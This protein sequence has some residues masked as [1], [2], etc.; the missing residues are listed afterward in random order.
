[1]A[2]SLTQGG[3]VRENGWARL[4]TRILSPE[5]ESDLDRVLASRVGYLPPRSARR[6]TR[7]KME[8]WEL[9]KVPDW[10]HGMLSQVS[11]FG[12][13]HVAFVE[14]AEVLPSPV[15]WHAKPQNVQY[16]DGWMSRRLS[17]LFDLTRDGKFRRRM[18]RYDEGFSPIPVFWGG[19]YYLVA[20][21]FRRDP[22]LEQEMVDGGYHLQTGITQLVEGD[23]TG[24][25]SVAELERIYSSFIATGG[26]RKKKL[27]SVDGVQ[28]KA[29]DITVTGAQVAREIYE[30]YDRARAAGRDGSALNDLDAPVLRW[31]QGVDACLK[32][33]CI[34]D[35]DDFCEV[36]SIP[37]EWFGDSGE[38][39]LLEL[40]QLPLLADRIVIPRPGEEVDYSEGIS[41][42]AA[43][44]AREASAWACCMGCPSDTLSFR[45]WEEPEAPFQPHQHI[46]PKQRK[47]ARQRDKACR[48]CRSEGADEVPPVPSSSAPG[49]VDRPSAEN[50]P[51]TTDHLRI[52]LLGDG[53]GTTGI[54]LGVQPDT[55]HLRS[56]KSVTVWPG[57][58][59]RIEISNPIQI[60]LGFSAHVTKSRMVQTHH[61][62]LRVRH[63]PTGGE[64]VG[65]F[66]RP[67]FFVSNPGNAEV[68]VE[69]GDILADFYLTW[70]GQGGPKGEV[71]VRPREVTIEYCEPAGGEGVGL[72][73][74]TPT[75]SYPRT[76]KEETKFLRSMVVHCRNADFDVYIGRRCLG[77]PEGVEV[78]WGNPFVV[79]TDGEREATVRKYEAWL[80][81][82]PE[83]CER[84]RRELKGKV[85]G[86]WCA[87]HLC[88]GHVLARVANS[89][90]PG[91]PPPM[92]DMGSRFTMTSTRAAMSAIGVPGIDSEASM[93]AMA[94]DLRP[95]IQYDH[96]TPEQQEQLA[97]DIAARAIAWE[98][99]LSSLPAWVRRHEQLERR[100]FEIVGVPFPEDRDLPPE[101]REEQPIPDPGVEP[102]FV[103]GE[104]EEERNA[105][106]VSG[107]P[108]PD[109][110]DGEFS[111]SPGE[112]LRRRL[113]GS[114]A[115]P[116]STRD[117]DTHL[118]AVVDFE[119]ARLVDCC[120]KL[121]ADDDPRRQYAESV[122]RRRPEVAA[123]LADDVFNNFRRGEPNT[124]LESSSLHLFEICQGME[125]EEKL[126]AAFAKVVMLS[127]DGHLDAVTEEYTAVTGESPWG[128]T[129]LQPDV[130]WEALQA[131]FPDPH[132]AAYLQ[133]Q[134]A[135][136]RRRQECTGD[137]ASLP[138]FLP[139]HAG[140]DLQKAIFVNWLQQLREYR[141]FEDAIALLRR[142]VDPD[143][144]FSRILLIDQGMLRML[145]MREV[146]HLMPDLI[147]VEK[148][149]STLFVSQTARETLRDCCRNPNGSHNPPRIVSNEEAKGMLTIVHSQ[150]MS[151]V[152]E[153]LRAFVCPAGWPVDLAEKLLYEV[154]Q[155]RKAVS[156]AKQGKQ[157][158]HHRDHD[159]RGPKEVAKAA[160]S[161]A[162]RRERQAERL[163]LIATLWQ[164]LGFPEIPSNAQRRLEELT[165][166]AFDRTRPESPEG[167]SE[168]GGQAPD[169]DPPGADANDEVE[170]P[171]DKRAKRK[172][173]ERIRRYQQS[174]MLPPC[175][176]ICN[177]H[178]QMGGIHLND[179]GSCECPI[180]QQA[181]LKA[182]A[183]SRKGRT[184]YVTNV[185]IGDLA[186]DLLV[187]LNDYTI[188]Q[189]VLVATSMQGGVK[190]E[191][192][193]IVA[194]PLESKEQGDIEKGLR[195]A[196][197]AAEH[198]WGMAPIKRVHSDREKGVL[199]TEEALHE[200]AI[201]LS[202][203]EGKA[204][205][206]NPNGELG[207][208]L[209]SR[210]ARIECAKFSWLP[211]DVKAFLFPWMCVRSA[212][213]MS[214]YNATAVPDRKTRLK[215]VDVPP[216]LSQVI[217]RDGLKKI[218]N[219]VPHGKL[220]WYLAPSMEVVGG[221]VVIEAEAPFR[222]F[223]TTTVESV[224][225]GGEWT[226]LKE[227]D[228]IGV[229]ATMVGRPSKDV[230]EEKRKAKEDAARARA[231]RKEIVE[232]AKEAARDARVERK[233]EKLRLAEKE[234][235]AKAERRRQARDEKA[236]LAD[237]ARE[238]KRKLK[239]ELRTL[240]AD[241][242]RKE[243]AKRARMAVPADGISWD[244]SPTDHGRSKGMTDQE[245]ARCLGESLKEA[246]IHLS[247]DSL[248]KAYEEM[249]RF[250][251]AP[252]DSDQ[253]QASKTAFHSVLGE[254]IESERNV[255]MADKGDFERRDEPW[256]FESLPGIEGLKWS[257]ESKDGRELTF[258]EEFRNAPDEEFEEYA[259][260]WATGDKRQRPLIEKGERRSP[261]A[262]V[263][264]PISMREAKERGEK[265]H[266]AVRTEVGRFM[267]FSAFGGPVARQGIPANARIYRGKL[268]YSIKYAELSEDQ[269]KDKARIVV[270]GCLRINRDGKI[271]LEKHFK[272]A[273]EYWAPVG[274]M[275]MLRY[276]ASAAAIQGLELQSTDLDS[277]YL[278]TDNHDHSLYLQLDQEIIEGLEDDWRAAVERAIQA[279][280]EMGG[281]GEVV[282]PVL[283]NVYGESD[284]GRSF[285][286]QY[287]EGFIKC[288]WTR[289]RAEPSL[290][291]KRCTATGRLQLLLSYVDDIAAA[292][293]P[294]DGKP[295]WDTMR[296]HGWKFSTE[297]PLTRFIGVVI[298]N[299]CDR[300][301]RLM[302]REYVLEVIRRHVEREG[303]L[304][305]RFTLPKDVPLPG[306]ETT[307]G[308][309]EADGVRSDIGGLMYAARG[310][311]P[312]IAFC[313]SKLAACASRWTPEARGFMRGVMS[314]L[315]GTID[316]A[317]EL[318]ARGFSSDFEDWRVIG[319]GDADY[320]APTCQTGVFQALVCASEAN[321]MR[322]TVGSK[323]VGVSHHE[324]ILAWD[325]TSQ[326]QTYVKL[327]V[328]EAEIVGLSLTA[329][330]VT[331]NVAIHAEV[332]TGIPERVHGEQDDGEYAIG[333]VKTDNDA[334][335]L[336]VNRGHSGKMNYL[337]KCYAIVLG[338]MH[339]RINA[340]ELEIER[341]DTQAMLADPLT[342]LLTTRVWANV[343]VKR[344][345]LSIDPE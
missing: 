170:T 120:R 310:T 265:Y 252:Q 225:T 223:N 190:D 236:R 107:H 49:G 163:R 334:A 57:E 342:K 229:P 80:L 341:E 77:M 280:L 345:I 121:F 230:A 268:I 20:C 98:W 260:G 60:P 300:R 26:A 277:G 246:G 248:T 45:M 39:T 196:I 92:K 69:E 72:A 113:R 188:F 108:Q 325:W 84:A 250:L 291:Y 142:G 117:P 82:Q 324:G 237:A 204:S 30:I 173:G 130:L 161:K 78:G 50:P 102:V 159:T 238:A 253:E 228:P 66:F 286:S 152:D 321:R 186:I 274:S 312:D 290:F 192:P 61:R 234:R 212:A 118:S 132:H 15:G 251:E 93:R 262:Y 297:E 296:S 68:V 247:G 17:V 175:D 149:E 29:E 232:T 164:P 242:K 171:G 103:D 299:P 155:Y 182:R 219:N 122:A 5:L 126:S 150:L 226:Y 41:R 166:D 202:L 307:D 1:M 34:P 100:V 62:E 203:T 105:R 330:G 10:A 216:F 240:R 109:W 187:R 305:P 340:G 306:E 25:V 46:T 40:A 308:L 110:T 338:W 193:V 88:H 167:D 95:D 43:A 172:K 114:N 267:Q 323:V 140:G 157:P 241:E 124:H 56:S 218:D 329:R 336:T 67:S 275:A 337:A 208:Q 221:S 205:Q 332:I 269:R 162:T 222:I 115:P 231:E 254:A 4:V 23:L 59:M 343:L 128:S 35:F 63:E 233:L 191:R 195:R 154:S 33:L 52:R 215:L 6:A 271:M 123:L 70:T 273:G 180:C 96:L 129:A 87:P 244:S 9:G 91:P 13:T 8:L 135:H 137:L 178:A 199:A 145:L 47:L 227:G 76:V 101:V 292:I 320:R 293:S 79:R 127:I 73:Q 54:L 284:A 133:E 276:V 119:E 213:E 311:R 283:K 22:F 160:N 74:D 282:F 201:W 51:A 139:Y 301:Y 58:G 339:E 31:R 266:K 263:T 322:R 288:G 287:Q 7:K 104:T 298:D 156:R 198:I 75:F 176:W 259:R 143:T 335:R 116:A 55:C 294:V 3:G 194:V 183:R 134:Y 21:F 243:I 316:V 319:W 209:V 333:C 184:E 249:L 328:A 71:L 111:T 235:E 289:C 258:S 257:V 217:F 153:T 174:R 220:G 214:A 24:T 206:A 147:S 185:S 86:C 158:V 344:G 83:L 97:Q 255:R 38:V 200:N 272:R 99:E 309:K 90:G 179:G 2:E 16:I 169:D 125:P 106:E 331:S 89:D 302:Q 94:T 285:I 181:N 295:L 148:A 131:V 189:Y 207:V 151:H 270:Q 317:L 318:D 304:T 278:Q 32:R 138:V 281:K 224:Y 315:L 112:R 37:R 48:L 168:L 239:A 44:L 14:Y 81:S 261:F 256:D 327:S 313:V 18:C 11:T 177:A 85:L 65:Q 27:K 314:Y 279:D 42:A 53:D 197:L 12:Y 326:K 19:A 165:I 210:G 64:H 144:V 28:V 211:E 141:A 264:T 146:R 36:R 245:A 136:E 303:P